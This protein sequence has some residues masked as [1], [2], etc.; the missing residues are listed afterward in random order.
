MMMAKWHVEGQSEGAK[1]SVETYDSETE[2]GSRVYVAE[3]SIQKFVAS[4]EE[5]WRG[6]ILEKGVV[7]G[8]VVAGLVFG[9]PYVQLVSEQCRL[10]DVLHRRTSRHQPLSVH[11]EVWVFLLLHCRFLRRTPLL[12]RPSNPG[13]VH[14]PGE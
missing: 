4:S 9:H 14:T 10:L 2:A 6:W 5:V 11:L 1:E 13:Q 12:P 8:C 3:G 7:E